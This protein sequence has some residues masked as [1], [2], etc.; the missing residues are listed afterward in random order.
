MG[1]RRWRDYRTAAGRRPV[2]DF[3]QE[4][5]DEDMAAVTTAMKEV[6]VHGLKA[7]RHL[8]NAIYEVR[9]YGS[10]VIYRLLFAP[11]GKWNQVLLA[12]VPFKKKTQR[13]PPQMVRLAERRLRDWES[14][15]R[16]R[17]RRL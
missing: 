12:L 1:K 15:G 6:E 14:R 11:Q 4:L 8:G 7:A 9:A 10:Q 16:N 17:N 5:N 13:T 2:N 3:L